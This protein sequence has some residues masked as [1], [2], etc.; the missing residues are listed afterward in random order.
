MRENT[1]HKDAKQE[2]KPPERT[3]VWRFRMEPGCVYVYRSNLIN[4]TLQARQTYIILS[5]FPSA[6]HKPRKMGAIQ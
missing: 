2:K 4:Q 1:K 6:P 3:E 5:H